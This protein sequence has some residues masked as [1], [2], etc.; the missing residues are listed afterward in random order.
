MNRLTTRLALLIGTL[1]V[2]NC[3]SK[4]NQNEVEVNLQNLAGSWEV[5]SFSSQGYT[6]PPSEMSSAAKEAGYKDS[7][8]KYQLNITESTL[9]YS[10]NDELGTVDSITKKYSLNGRTIS[11]QK[12][13]NSTFSDL[14]VVSLQKSSMTLKI[15]ASANSDELIIN[16]VRIE[17][18]E[19]VSEK[20]KPIA[21]NSYYQLSVGNQKLEETFNGDFRAP[22]KTGAQNKLN[23]ALYKNNNQTYLRLSSSVI[24]ASEVSQDGSVTIST[25]GNDPGYSVEAL[26]PFNFNGPSDMIK[27]TL[28]K[29]DKTNLV[30]RYNKNN[31]NAQFN[32]GDSSNCEMNIHRIKRNLS[33]SIQCSNLEVASFSGGLPANKAD[34]LLSK[35]CILEF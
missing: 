22:Y 25:N 16:L 17:K 11:P 3:A 23:C 8:M 34:L 6:I 31:V 30:G 14:E 4:K 20:A 2:I 24:Y 13:K 28:K 10:N 33:I 1:A 26:T 5:S 21:Q 29:S 18:S 35:Q 9:T 19:L 15:N 7:S 27:T 32:L 12:S